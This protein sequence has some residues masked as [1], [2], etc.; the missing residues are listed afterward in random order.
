M[1]EQEQW[2]PVT[3]PEFAAFY[4]V[5]NLGLIRKY[6]G[7][8]L[9]PS[10]AGPHRHLQLKLRMPSGETKNVLVAHLV[11]GAFRESPDGRSIGYRDGN[12]RNCAFA[13]LFFLEKSSTS[14]SGHARQMLTLSVAK[15]SALLWEELLP[16]TLPDLADHATCPSYQEEISSH[17]STL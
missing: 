16:Q 6:N 12:S 3:L 1:S 4:E 11:M 2:R 14:G 17:W 15:M 5:S 7:M 9:R 13:N 10:P 8:V